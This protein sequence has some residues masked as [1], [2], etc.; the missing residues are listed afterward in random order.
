M[1]SDCSR[2]WMTRFQR[3][4][5]HKYFFQHSS[6]QTPSP[7]SFVQEFDFPTSVLG[8]GSGGVSQ[9]DMISSMIFQ[10]SL[11]HPSATSTSTRSSKTHQPSSS[12]AHKASYSSNVTGSIQAPSSS[13][14]STPSFVTRSGNLYSTTSISSGVEANQLD[15][16]LISHH[17][18]P[19]MSVTPSILSD[20]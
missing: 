14:I 7:I 1:Q 17:Q 12:H 13:G 4:D 11:S 18:Q 20:Q 15:A 5:C 8:S 6:A 19:M 9:T 16:N 3:S 2:L 10:P